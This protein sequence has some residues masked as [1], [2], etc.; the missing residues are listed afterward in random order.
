MGTAHAWAFGPPHAPP[1]PGPR[2][3]GARLPATYQHVFCQPPLFLSQPAGY[4]EGE[5]LLPEERVPAVP[6]PEGDDFPAVGQ[7][8]DEGHLW[9]ARPV[10]HQGLC[11]GGHS[12]GERAA[13]PPGGGGSPGQR[14]RARG[15]ADLPSQL[16]TRKGY[17]YFLK[18]EGIPRNGGT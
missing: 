3:A 7:V 15:E 8:G 13:S 16:R 1:P 12:P 2:R 5:A 18:A 6:T 17:T 4:P 9:V 10:V 14:P 11:A